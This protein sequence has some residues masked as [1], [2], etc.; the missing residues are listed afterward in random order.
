MNEQPMTIDDALDHIR[1][2]PKSNRDRGAS[3]ERLMQSALATHPGEFGTLRFERIVTWSEWE[4][5]AGRPDT[6]IDLIGYQHDGKL[7]VIQCKCY[8]A[9]QKVLKGDID[10]FIAA[11]N[12]PEF[13]ARILVNTGDHFSPHAVRLMSEVVPHVELILLE[14][15]RQW[16]VDDW[17]ACFDDRELR[18]KHEPFTPLPHQQAAVSN[19]INGFNSADRGK[20]IMPCGTGKSA[21]ALW[22][23]EK[24]ARRGGSVLY[25]VPSIALMGQTMREWAS[26]RSMQHRYIGVC[27][28]SRSGKTAEDQTLAELTIPVTTDLDQIAGSMRRSPDAMTV[29]FSTYQSLQV[30]VEAQKSAGAAFDLIVCDEAHRTCGVDRGGDSMFHL[31]HDNSKVRADKRLYMTAT[32]KVFASRVIGAAR[33][34]DYGVYSMDDES[35]YGPELHRLTFGKAIEDKLLADYEVI[36]VAADS[37][38]LRDTRAEYEDTGISQDDA[39]KFAGVIDALADPNTT[40]L[41]R[42]DRAAGTVNPLCAAKRAIAFNTT[43]AQSKAV[44]QH[45]PSVAD[46]LFAK[47][48]SETRS[49]ELVDLNVRHIDGKS[50]ALTRARDIQWLRD[51]DTGNTGCLMLTNARCLTEGVDVPAL[52]AVVFM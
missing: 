46:S 22:I 44:A 17:G 52:D 39:V 49:K 50:D 12:R 30:V 37:T 14:D 1:S 35:V 18:W 28:D 41:T 16:K 27:S 32:P 31:I 42:P 3:F 29:V 13:G 26:N 21:T 25:L 36:V 40:G 47:A 6:G 11:S 10:G 23:A 7:A 33:D 4:G 38:I 24:Q 51:G 19:V 15:M 48:S 43:I 34:K 8:S 5:A 9:G 45:L 2:Q 20:M